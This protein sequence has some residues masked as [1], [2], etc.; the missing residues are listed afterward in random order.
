[1]V[2]VGVL[3]ENDVLVV[4]FRYPDSGSTIEFAQ[5]LGEADPQ[6]SALGMDTYSICVDA[7]L[8]F[9]GGVEGWALVGDSLAFTLTEAAAEALGVERKHTLSLVPS[10]DFALLSASLARVMGQPGPRA[11]ALHG[12]AGITPDF[13]SGLAPINGLRHR[14]EGSTTGWFLWAGE[15]FPLADDAFQPLHLAHLSTR[16][17]EA[18]PYLSLEPGWRFLIAPGYVDVWSD[19]SL[20]EV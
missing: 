14:P 19:P 13:G 5:D 8:V 4:A 16:C 12:I 11:H 1:M 3:E 7:G 15:E 10:F 18:L 17:P 9:Y 2:E 6:D 20:L